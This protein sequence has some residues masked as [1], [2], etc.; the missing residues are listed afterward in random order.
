VLPNCSVA[1]KTHGSHFVKRTA[2]VSFSAEKYHFTNGKR[3]FFPKAF[4][5]VRVKPSLAYHHIRTKANLT[6]SA[7]QS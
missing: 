6:V 4:E 5:I 7:V 2:T 1:N 3:R